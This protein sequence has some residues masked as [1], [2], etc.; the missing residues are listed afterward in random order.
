LKKDARQ[1][2]RDIGDVLTRLDEPEVEAAAPARSRRWVWRAAAA[3]VLLVAGFSGYRWWTSLATGPFQHIQITSL[4][5]SGKAFAA[6]V[7]PDGKYVLHSVSDE[8]K[9]SLWLLHVATGSN[10]Q[11]QAPTPGSFT[12]L[13]FSHDGNSLYYVLDTGTGSANMVTTGSQ[14]LYTMPV[15]GGNARKVASFDGLASAAISPDEKRLV[16]TKSRAS[17]SLSVANLDGSGQRQLAARTAPEYIRCTAWSPDGRT[18]AFGA[19]SQNIRVDSDLIALP[20]AGGAERHI[21]G[22]FAGQMIFL[23][24]MPD[25]NGLIAT[26]TSQVP[27]PQ[28]CYIAYPGGRARSITNDL[29]SYIDISLT[30]DSSALVTLQRETVSHLW[31][32]PP[33]DSGSAREISTGRLDGL[34]SVVFAGNGGLYF[35]APESGRDTQIWAVAADGAGRRQITKGEGLAGVPAV[36]GD[37]RHLVF[38]S[39][40]AG[41]P[42]I[43]LSDLDGGNIRQLTH[44]ESETRPSCSPDGTWLTHTET[45][46]DLGVWRMAMDGGSRVRLWDQRGYSEI[47]PDGKFVLVS[48]GKT[49]VTIL[50]AGGGPPVQT[51]EGIPALGLWGVVHW[52]P[53]GKALLYGKT[54]AGVTNIWQQPLNGGEPKQLTAFASQ[55]ITAFDISRDGKRLVLARG[56]ARSD[57]V[58][59]R[60]L[61]R[62]PK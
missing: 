19:V 24:W 14:V 47:S 48:D 16:F 50:P 12:N 38:V 44:G 58:L 2:L 22:R 51:L 28:L 13:R 25:G 35:E 7:S 40:R 11:L 27:F 5:D 34:N 56:T 33:G 8:G 31:V 36:C 4:T 3:V 57:V 15:L 59:I 10:V 61:D 52:S 37:D 17:L 9:S 62:M 54:V 41:G 20:A 43:F 46:R 1:R 39:Y 26:I 6:A 18:I 42:H 45:G 55:R 60:D 23:A 32:V 53:N 49:K 29:N 21:S 30:Q